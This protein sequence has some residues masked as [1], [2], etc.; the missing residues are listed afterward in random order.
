MNAEAISEV[1]RPTEVVIVDDSTVIRQ[2]LR[3]LVNS[4]D[5]V[6]VA[7]EAGDGAAGLEIIRNAR[8]DVVILDIMMPG[9]SG[10]DVLK[11]VKASP[12]AP[13]V[14]VLT[15]YPYSAFRQRSIS[16][17]AE[18]FLVKATEFDR[19]RGILAGLRHAASGPALP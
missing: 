19:I 14:I 2:R 3:A 9:A 4:L 13:T 17:G 12:E 5:G 7:G 8:P 1:E 18:H 11:E 15:N 6:V 10:L 16:L